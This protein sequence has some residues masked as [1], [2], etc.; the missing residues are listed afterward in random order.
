M[1]MKDAQA[2][3]IPF[4]SRIESFA[5]LFLLL[6]LVFISN[7]CNAVVSFSTR[8]KFSLYPH[9]LFLLIVRKDEKET[10]SKIEKKE[11]KP[12]WQWNLTKQD[13]L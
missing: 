7:H 9:D 1:E 10:E 5:H 2:H 11:T 4:Y 6:H 12:V 13:G 3:K 8:Q